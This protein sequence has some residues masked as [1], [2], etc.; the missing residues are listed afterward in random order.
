MKFIENFCII[1][2]GV[3][4]KYHIKK[5]NKNILFI[6]AIIFN[7]NNNTTMIFFIIFTNKL[8]KYIIICKNIYF[9]QII[10]INLYS[11]NIFTQK[12]IKLNVSL[13]NPNSKKYN[14]KFFIVLKNNIY[15]NILLFFKSKFTAL[16][17][18]IFRSI[19]IGIGISVLMGLMGSMGSITVVTLGILI[20]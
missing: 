1:K 16:L 3:I 6:I 9:L 10:I 5:T 11:F 19:S 15:L 18:G 14:N 12:L 20:L 17:N 13:L 2:I 7:K 8:K 4:V